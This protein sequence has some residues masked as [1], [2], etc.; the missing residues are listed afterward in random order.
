MYFAAI[1]IY[2]GVGID[3]PTW[4]V[5]SLLA[6]Y[7]IGFVAVKGQTLGK[8]ATHIRVAR[9]DNG[10]PPGWARSARRWLLPAVGYVL[11]LLPGM[12]IQLS[13][14]RDRDRQGAHDR[15]TKTLVVQA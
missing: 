3:L 8:M 7:E 13:W 10:A 15:A 5:L 6:A 14:L 4:S 9:I 12:L 2:S 1:L 11:L